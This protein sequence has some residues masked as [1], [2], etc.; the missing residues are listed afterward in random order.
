MDHQNK[1]KHHFKRL[2]LEDRGVAFLAQVLIS[3]LITTV[4][5]TSMIRAIYQAHDQ[6]LKEYRR[7]RALEELQNELEYWK[8]RVF[9]RGSGYG[10]VEHSRQVVLDEGR[11]STDDYIMGEFSPAAT[12]EQIPTTGSVQSYEITVSIRWPEGGQ[13][14]RETLRT[15]ITRAITE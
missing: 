15:G 3:I 10:I 12:I 2:I 7:M 13:M 5:S 14:R 6:S 4:V 1:T 11:R 9:V 8:A